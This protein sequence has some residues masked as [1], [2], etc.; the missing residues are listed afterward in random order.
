MRELLVSVLGDYFIG[1]MLVLEQFKDDSPFALRLIEGVKEV[2][3]EANIR[4][5]VKIL[6]DGQQRTS[7]LFYA[8]YEPQIPLQ[9]RKNAYLFF[10]DL[11]KALNQK[12]DE[13]V[14]GV[15]AGDKKN[16]NEIRKSVNILPFSSL[17][18]IGE[19]AKSRHNDP[20]ATE[21][22]T[23]ANDFMNRQVNIV[24]LP[25][26]ADLEKIVETFQRINR[27][28]EP[29]STF[30][31][32]TARLYKNDIR[33]RE[34]LDKAKGLY[35]FTESVDPDYILRVIALI[36]GKEPKRK[37]ILELEPV[38]FAA[39]WDR[40]CEA[41]ETAFKRATDVKNGY[42]VFNFKKWMPYT[43]MIV[44]LAALMDFVREIKLENK[45][46]YDKI[47]SWYWASVFSNRY[48]QASDSKSATDFQ[49]VSHWIK[50]NNKIPQTVK[51]FDPKLVDLETDKQGSAI[52]KGVINLIVLE[53]ALDFETGQ[54]PQFSVDKINDDHIFPKSVYKENRILNRTLI[55][56]N[57][58]KSDK[59]PSV[60]FTERQRQHG[61]DNL[62]E[63]LRSHLIPEHALES[64]LNKDLTAFMDS[65]KASII[66]KISQRMKSGA[67]KEARE[68]VTPV[69][70]HLP[71][72]WTPKAPK[73]TKELIEKVKR[74]RKEGYTYPEV[75]DILKKEDN[76][77]ITPQ[78]LET[79]ISLLR[80]R[81]ARGARDKRS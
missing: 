58:R 72:N 29:L 26:N 79:R 50:D 64:L 16:L 44:P 20:R 18:N 11:D 17:R 63:I 52:Y 34:L 37:N 1:S 4:S 14:T 8:L 66:E 2:N 59:L 49:E 43:P 24:S 35:T 69:E 53:G 22:L 71:R 70:K 61:K 81:F 57:K 13:A 60:Y 73:Y 15:S 12:W 5:I 78:A 33:L 56:T 3:P 47:D 45:Q 40:A 46:S 6:L 41:I 25:R 54:P 23:L 30:E 75:C 38:G 10:L 65:R 67:T 80:Q 42:G 7:A 62:K 68:I 19:L 51:D 74:L 76:F 55:S 9:N 77:P 32:V 27:T 21:I 39:D 48:D 31:L 28:G 36:R